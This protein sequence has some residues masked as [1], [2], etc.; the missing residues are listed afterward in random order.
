MVSRGASRSCRSAATLI[1]S[2]AI[3]R[4]RFLL[5]ALPRFPPS[6][7]APAEPVELA[8]PL[9]RSIAREQLD[10]LDRQEQLVAARVMDLQ[11]IVRG[12]GG[13]DI[14]QTDEP[15]DAV[16]DVDDE[17]PGAKTRHLGDEIGGTLAAAP[18]PHQPVAQNVLLAD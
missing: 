16:V 9:L 3:S 8:T 17:V 5:R 10:V 14:A 1:S 18:R 6:P 15:A 7:P 11:A 12:A 13:L 4:M 2:P